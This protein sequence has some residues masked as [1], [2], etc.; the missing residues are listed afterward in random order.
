MLN[1]VWDDWELPSDDWDPPP[2]PTQWQIEAAWAI[3]H[4]RKPPPIRV[5]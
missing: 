2:V 5:R 1:P 3:L 4:N